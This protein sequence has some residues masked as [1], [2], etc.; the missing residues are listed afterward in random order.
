MRLVERM[1]Q[2]ESEEAEALAKKAEAERIKLQEEE[3]NHK[4]P[5]DAEIAQLGFLLEMVKAAE[6]LEE[7][8]DQIWGRGTVEPYKG[9]SD[10]R[11]LYTSVSLEPDIFPS[12]SQNRDQRCAGYLLRVPYEGSVGFTEVKIYTNSYGYPTGRDVYTVFRNVFH[13]ARI[14]VEVIARGEAGGILR[15][16]SSIEAPRAQTPSESHKKILHLAEDISR[17]GDSQKSRSTLQDMLARSC[18]RL[19]SIHD[20]DVNLYM[21]AQEHQRRSRGSAI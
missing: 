4:A 1:S 5:I 18:N 2:L 19:N 20:G 7:A 8:R 15:V 10:H 3:A 16:N 21:I 9:W 11:H 14:A 6:Q 13:E 17:D 12:D